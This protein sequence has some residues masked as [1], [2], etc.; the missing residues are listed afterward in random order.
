MLA[1]R[2]TPTLWKDI[3][4][5]SLVSLGS[6]LL[7]AL[8][9]G[10]LV[11]LLTATV[12]RAELTSNND[13]AAPARFDQLGRGSLLLKLASGGISVDAPVLHTDVVMAVSGMLARVS[14]RQRFLNPGKQWTEG[15]YV[16]PLP[17]DA[18]V[19]RMQLRIG[20][21]IIEGEIQEREQAEKTYKRA[22]K[23]GKKA[24]L[25][26]QQRPNIFTT[27]VANIGPGEEV[28]VEIEYQQAL[29]YNQ[30]AFSLRFPLVVAP[31]YI[32][33]RP[34]AGEEEVSFGATGWSPNTT[35]V[36]DASRITPPVADSSDRPINPVRIQVNLDAG[37]PLARLESRY[38]PVHIE[39]EQDRHRI[40]LQ[41]GQVPMDRDFELIWV[42]DQGQAP[43][44]ALFS[45]QWADKDYSLLMLLPPLPEAARSAVSAREL[46]FV[47]DTSGSMH[48]ASIAQARSALKLALNRLQP[49]D[50]FNL[51]QFNNR[52]HALFRQA[53]PASSGNIR[54]ALRYVDS[55]EAEGGTEMLPALQRALDGEHT[56]GLLRQVIF[57]T[58]GSVG[59]E[60]ELFALIRQRLG[61]S[62]LFTIGI[63]SAPNSFFM[64]R[65]ARFGRGSFTYIGTTDEVKEKM[66][67]L[68]GKLES[69]VFTDIEVVWPSA[70]AA[71]MYPQRIPDLY[72]GEP[73]VLAARLRT[74][75]DRLELRGK[76]NGQPWQQQVDLRGGG[77]SAGVHVFWAR[78]KIAELMDQRSA[79]V[80]EEEVRAAVLELAL[81]HRLVSRY[82]SLVAVDKT[83]ARPVDEALE[84]RPVP[85]N[86]PH[87]WSAD[88]V[89]GEL[90]QT[91][92][93]APLQLLLGMLL[94]MTGIWFAR[95]ARGSGCHG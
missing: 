15:I 19:D 92:T 62:R 90:P 49:D 5:T 20:E 95:F 7:A 76:W 86:L 85:T 43:Q 70:D 25:L 36:P 34:L 22:R 75:V 29:R 81:E 38:H 72:L 14:V 41:Q 37:F 39:Q 58:D 60:K 68:F 52:T 47:I 66:G 40:R 51:I 61:S 63:G 82:T 53:A 31:R 45:E 30:G 28:Q 50:R 64:T 87:G 6:G 77:A 44:A 21:R 46:V 65:A 35:K 13:A 74:G 71:D 94:L 8:I 18:A 57:L 27:A 2:S 88:R 42:P 17:E 33:G 91:A 16:F 79:G 26:S 9:L 24:S 11:F 55:L 4:F 89:F 73:V 56:E 67:A 84:T 3:A 93:S 23:E 1:T 12:A 83:P 80:A 32:P 48:G 10:G 59:N 54:R 78:R 69:P